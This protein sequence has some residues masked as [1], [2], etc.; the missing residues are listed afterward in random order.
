MDPNIGELAWGVGL[1]VLEVFSDLRASTVLLTLPTP[2]RKLVVNGASH[3]SKGFW[4]QMQ[5]KVLFYFKHTWAMHPLGWLHFPGGRC[6]GGSCAFLVQWC[7]AGLPVVLQQSVP[8]LLAVQ[9]SP[10][11][12]TLPAP[13]PLNTQSYCPR[14]HMCVCAR[15]CLSEQTLAAAAISVDKW[16]PIEWK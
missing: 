14:V 3:E 15:V 8:P 13:S 1:H 6:L 12:S 16:T 4:R 7:H 2:G 11:K 10:G 9:R 5:R